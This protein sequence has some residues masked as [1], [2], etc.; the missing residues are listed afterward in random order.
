MRTYLF[1]FL[2]FIFF[3]CNNST[4]EQLSETII[5]NTT[6]TQLEYPSNTGN[7]GDKV[8]SLLGYGYDATGFCDTT[9]G[10]AKILDLTLIQ[11]YSDE[12][13]HSYPTFLSANNFTELTN[14]LT[15][16]EVPQVSFSAYTLSAHLKSLV[17][18]AFHTD[19]ID[20]K[21]AFSYYSVTYVSPRFAIPMF[22]DLQKTLS[23]NFQNDIN[24]LTLQQ[25]VSKYG[26]HVL[27]QVILGKKSEVL[28]STE[29]SD[30]KSAEHG[31]YQRMQQ[32]MGSMAGISVINYDSKSNN[33]KERMIYNTIGGNEK[34][35]GIIN[36]TDYNP[37]K[38]SVD[39]YSTLNT[40]S[41]LQF[42]EVGKNDLIPLYDLINDPIKKQEIK[43]YIEQYIA[44]KSDMK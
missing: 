13:N 4:I 43:L 19:S 24:L 12:I 41:K 23:I 1:V 42:I 16:S 3:S 18:L 9:S 7:S 20:S 44:S 15:N 39:I 21:Y 28:Y 2:A 26:T 25:L 35:F 33:I 36:A 30:A 37:D 6:I 34:M 8:T 5:P 40:S 29:T 10:R 31:L 22:T 11:I 32:F 38:L 27:T 14:R 17:K